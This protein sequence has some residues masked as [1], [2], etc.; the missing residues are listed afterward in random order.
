MAG[1]GAHKGPPAQGRARPPEDRLEARQRGSL[2]GP[3]GELALLEKMPIHSGCRMAL[4][5]DG[6][7][8]SGWGVGTQTPRPHLQ[9]N[10]HIGTVS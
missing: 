6:W 7:Q 5:W 9:S 2:P 1:Q 8:L 4:K 3:D 10:Y